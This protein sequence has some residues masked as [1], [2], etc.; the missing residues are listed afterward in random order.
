MIQRQGPLWNV[1]TSRAIK[2]TLPIS[3]NYVGN[4][5]F[6]SHAFEEGCFWWMVGLVSPILQKPPKATV[7]Y[8][9]RCRPFNPPWTN[10][11]CST[12]CSFWF[13]L[14]SIYILRKWSLFA[15]WLTLWERT[16][17]KK[18]QGTMKLYIWETGRRFAYIVQLTAPIQ[19]VHTCLSN[20]STNRYELL[21]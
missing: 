16:L 11:V 4:L 19:I 10:G 15:I 12:L 7:I 20:L 2:G 5:F 13:I 1:S 9:D 6:N 14:G 17:R 21:G 8:V 18:L 3:Q